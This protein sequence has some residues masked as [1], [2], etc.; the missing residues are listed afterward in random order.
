[1]ITLRKAVLATA[2]ISTGLLSS[3]GMASAAGDDHSKNDTAAASS[4]QD[5]ATQQ[6]GVL[7]SEKFAPNV[8]PTVC[9]N[10]VP[11]NVLGVQVPVQDVAGGLS[12]LSDTPE[13]TSPGN[14]KSCTNPSAS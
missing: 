6:D 10:D 14:A 13:G 4:Q 12:L 8:N 1:M 2:M 11:V 5:G 9:N 3:T 7:N